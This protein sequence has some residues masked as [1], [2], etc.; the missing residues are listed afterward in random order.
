LGDG[1]SAVASSVGHREIGLVTGDRAPDD[2][3]RPRLG[4]LP[5]AQSLLHSLANRSG[6]FLGQRGFRRL[7]VEREDSDRLDGRG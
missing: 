7:I 4:G 3:V 5:E 6:N 2:G 1:H